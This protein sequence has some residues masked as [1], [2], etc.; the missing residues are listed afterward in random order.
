LSSNYSYIVAGLG[1]PGREY[2]FTRHNAG[3]LALDY[4]YQKHNIKE[5]KV[6]FHSVLA[7]GVI[8]GEKILF[9]RPQTYM[10]ESGVA[11]GE[12][13]RFYNIPPEKVL[14]I[15]DDISLEPGKIRL[16]R[17]GSAGGHNGIKSIINHLSSQDFPR[18]KIGVGGV[19]NPDYDMKD[20]V[21]GSFSKQDKEKLFEAFENVEKALCEMLEKGIDTAM[22]HYN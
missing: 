15:F 5:G 7:E 9:L 21:L 13:A 6:K 12:A 17:K 1:N 2:T 8:A 3:Y 19:P 18:I 22:C 14:V 20:W 4:I 16:R 10:N 11:I